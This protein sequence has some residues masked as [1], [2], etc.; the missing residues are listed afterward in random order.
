M[1]PGYSLRAPAR[2]VWY[3]ATFGMSVSGLAAYATI[4]FFLR[5]IERI[6]MWPFVV[7][8]LLLG[9]VILIAVY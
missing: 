8:R 7:Y 4:F 2:T 3:Q 1:T 9:A 5:F 6:G